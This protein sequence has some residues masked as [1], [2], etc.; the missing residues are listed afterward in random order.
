MR[1]QDVRELSSDEL[2]AKISD[3][4]KEIVDLRFQHAARK[5]ESPA[6]LRQAK[7]LLARLMTIQTE[8]NKQ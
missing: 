5:L 4:C 3:T 7:H 8:K 1:L 6:K 2:I